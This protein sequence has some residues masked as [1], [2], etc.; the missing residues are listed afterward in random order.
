MRAS[1]A[2][3]SVCHV[4]DRAELTVT[5]LS[6]ETTLFA[7][8]ARGLAYGFGSQARKPVLLTS[9]QLLPDG[10]VSSAHP[11]SL[12]AESLPQIRRQRRSAPWIGLQMVSTGHSDTS[13]SSLQGEVQ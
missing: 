11:E 8:F 4:D 2:G 13:P 10:Q 5:A 7:A 3:H 12:Q 6:P 9:T 1:R